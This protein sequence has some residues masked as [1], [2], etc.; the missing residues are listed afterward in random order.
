MRDWTYLPAAD[1]QATIAIVPQEE[2]H[3]NHQAGK[4]KHFIIDSSSYYNTITS[5]EKLTPPLHP[6]P[7]MQVSSYLPLAPPT[8]QGSIRSIIHGG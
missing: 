7:L 4:K 2:A 5:S 8:S 1:Q 6:S 3:K